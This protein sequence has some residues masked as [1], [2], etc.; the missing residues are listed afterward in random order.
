[1]IET[2]AIACDLTC[3]VAFAPH[4]LVDRY[5]EPKKDQVMGIKG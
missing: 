4:K 1:M 2:K 5:S 3:F